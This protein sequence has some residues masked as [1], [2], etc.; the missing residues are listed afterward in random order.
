MR[1][2]FSSGFFFFRRPSHLSLDA[3]L[4]QLVAFHLERCS[5]SRNKLYKIPKIYFTNASGLL[6]AKVIFTMT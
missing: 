4:P 1:E 6:T 3:S 2:T 5:M